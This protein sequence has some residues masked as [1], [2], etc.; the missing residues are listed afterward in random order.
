MIVINK[1]N[2]ILLLLNKDSK[3]IHITNNNI[4]LLLTKVKANKMK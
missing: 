3:E 1:V 2:K 4:K